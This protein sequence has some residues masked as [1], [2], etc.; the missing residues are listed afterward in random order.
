MNQA[1]R[2][3]CATAR[4]GFRFAFVSEIL[5]VFPMDTSNLS[6]C[7]ILQQFEQQIQKFAEI[8]TAPAT[9]K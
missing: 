5:N 9:I 6:S 3:S 4:N 1:K 8:L 2:N 7:L